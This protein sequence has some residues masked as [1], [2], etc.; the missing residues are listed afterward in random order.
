MGSTSLV[1][2][3]ISVI[4]FATVLLIPG[5]PALALLGPQAEPAQIDALRKSL[6]L[7]QPVAV[8]YGRW[9]SRAL[10]GD[11]GIS[12]Q[13]REPVATAIWSRLRNTALLTSGALIIAIG[14]GLPLGIFAVV[15][16]RSWLDRIAM[17]IALVGNSLP[18]FWLGLILIIVFGQYLGWLPTSGMYSVREPGGPFDLARHLVLP[19][20]TLSSVSLALVARFTRSAMLETIGMDYV[21]TA[22]AKG[23]GE[24][25]VIV[26]HVLQNAAIPIV[27]IV[28]LQ[29]GYLLGGAVLTETVFS[30]PGVGLQLFRAIQSRDLPLIQGTV[31]VI[32]FLFVVINLGVDVL[33]AYLDPRIRYG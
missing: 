1:L 31:L 28:G 4:V 9:L 7:D 26:R 6:G 23:A 17:V 22:R 2:L 27:T 12:L 33:Y 8:Q 19:A 14:A 18:S 29:L 15:G 32:A 16:H 13:L 3:G 30:W 5:D 21:R 25:R 11:L 20:I 24:P 10:R